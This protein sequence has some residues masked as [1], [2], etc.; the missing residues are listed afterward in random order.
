MKDNT[1][2]LYFWQ[3]AAEDRTD[4][5]VSQELISEGQEYS[6][7]E[8]NVSLVSQTDNVHEEVITS[9]LSYT[10][11]V[12]YDIGT[13]QYLHYAKSIARSTES[14]NMGHHVTSSQTDMEH[15]EAITSTVSYTQQV[16]YDIGTQQYLHHAKSF[17]TSTD[18][19]NIGYVTSSLSFEEAITSSKQYLIKVILY[20]GHVG[21]CL[22]WTQFR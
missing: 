14:Q 17:A 7:T 22:K 18:S 9:T 1:I 16:Q 20:S 19:Q 15:E 10:Q 13:Q 12:H 6:V 5:I 3:I 8:N 2:F 4:N 21:R 11:Q